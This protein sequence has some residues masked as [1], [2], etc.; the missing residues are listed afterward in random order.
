ML[1]FLKRRKTGGQLD[2]KWRSTKDFTYSL[3]SLIKRK[4]K[5]AQSQS[6]P[7]ITENKI[8]PRF[9]FTGARARSSVEAHLK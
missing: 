3:R 6:D 2:R 7:F 9:L 4:K 1:P 8:T 5:A